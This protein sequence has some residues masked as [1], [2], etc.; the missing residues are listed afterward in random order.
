M[1]FLRRR[2]ASPA[3]AILSETIPCQDI[4]G[5]RTAITIGIT[6][7]GEITITSPAGDTAVF[8][9]PMDIGPVRDALRHAAM[10]AGTLPV[11]R[12]IPDVH[13]TLQPEG[14]NYQPV[15]AW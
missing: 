13:P 12:D 11:G 15:P 2:P 6:G 8:A 4:T 3:I 7:N 9:E 14:T 1:W 5:R 10:T